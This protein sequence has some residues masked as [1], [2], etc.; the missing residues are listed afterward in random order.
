[1]SA[2][3]LRRAL[4]PRY[5]RHGANAIDRSHGGGEVGPVQRLRRS[6]KIVMPGDGSDRRGVLLRLLGRKLQL[7][8]LQRDRNP[9]V[10]RQ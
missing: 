6:A 8:R 2:A 3:M 10:D 1:M 7:R 9:E 5:D 4:A